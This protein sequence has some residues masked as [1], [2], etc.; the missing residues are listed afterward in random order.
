[1]GIT[2]SRN[3]FNAVR[4]Y[5]PFFCSSSQFDVESGLMSSSTAVPENENDE[6]KVHETL[7]YGT[8]Q[9]NFTL[10]S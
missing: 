7:Y 6:A 9:K 4:E 3:L 1:M 10:H 2:E 8:L 5:C